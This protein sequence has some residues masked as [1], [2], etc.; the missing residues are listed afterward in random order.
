MQ[1]LLNLRD[2]FALIVGTSI[3]P[4]RQSWLPSANPPIKKRRP[5]AKRLSSLPSVSML[6]RCW[7][8]LIQRRPGSCHT[9]SLIRN[10]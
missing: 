6:T 2:L 4:A 9:I 3:L 5:E 8:S 1:Y 7:P 10:L